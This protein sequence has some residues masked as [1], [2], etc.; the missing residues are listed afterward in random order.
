M[1]YFLFVSPS[2][3]IICVA[4]SA[5]ILLGYRKY[6]CSA[7]QVPWSRRYCDRP[8]LLNLI[9]YAARDTFCVL[10]IYYIHQVRARYV[11]CAPDRIK[12]VRIK[13]LLEGGNRFYAQRQRV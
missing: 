6:T 10:L 5:Y 4:N 9:D 3:V 7:Q 12:R 2:F 13:P 8:R 1:L 11:G